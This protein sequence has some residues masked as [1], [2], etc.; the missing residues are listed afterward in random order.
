MQYIGWECF[1]ALVMSI[2][3]LLSIRLAF[4]GLYGRAA[5]S[6]SAGLAM[7]GTMLFLVSRTQILTSAQATEVIL[8]L[9]TV[10]AL[11]LT[12]F[13]SIWQRTCNKVHIN[14]SRIAVSQLH[15]VM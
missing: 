11:M 8:G 2:L 1:C 10:T 5:L 13:G 14:P 7:E 6:L 15:Q 12:L 4:G 3:S 9:H